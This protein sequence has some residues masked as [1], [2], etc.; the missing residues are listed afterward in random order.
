MKILITAPSLNE[1]DN[2]SGISTLIAAI[3]SG[4]K[5]KFVHFPAGRKDGDKFDVSW[6]VNQA[7]LPFAFSS[8]IKREKPDVVHIN[9]AFEPR[10]IIRD[11]I[12]AGRAKSAGL[13]V[14][15]HVHNG[16]YVLNEFTSSALA[17][18]AE[19]LLKNADKIVVLG[20]AE[21]D[22][23]LKR[24]P[25]LDITV[26]PNAVQ[27]DKIPEP[28]RGHGEKTII[29][30]GRLNVT[31]GLE[32]IVEVCRMLLEQ[33]FKF[34][35]ACYG[36]GPDRDPFVS[37]M[38]GLLG[39]KFH[40]GG[41]AFGPRKWQAL[42]EAD[43]FLLPSRHEGLPMAMLEAMAAGCVPVV[44]DVGTITDV[45]KDGRNGFIIEP[46]NLTQIA[47][48]LKMILS[49]SEVAWNDLRE[50][51][52]K[53]VR[54]RYNFADYIAKLDKIYEEVSAKRVSNV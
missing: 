1:N 23:L 50:N 33:G 54:Q 37:N 10:A 12:L 6:F 4:S 5:A 47:G 13:P 34:K 7:K 36:A 29:F 27:V 22:N 39:E 18:R 31:K 30:F 41:V 25:G 24:T 53:T 19:K 49:E 15:L 28:E 44:S 32:D 2:V 8:A 26:L 14:V 51:A 43:I 21:R 3:I 35:F 48:K 40:D 52:K 46:G 38:K 45:V 9:T 20:N 11:L 17:R 42:S 16:K